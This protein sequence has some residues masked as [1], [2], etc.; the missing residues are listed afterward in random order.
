MLNRGVGLIRVSP[1]CWPF[2]L[3]TGSI[4]GA[5]TFQPLACFT[6]DLSVAVATVGE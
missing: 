1:P 2:A 3:G 6:I 4:P 5:S